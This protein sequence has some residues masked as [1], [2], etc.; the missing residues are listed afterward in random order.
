MFAML[1]LIVVLLLCLVL[2]N[3]AARAWLVWFVCVLTLLA[4]AGAVLVATAVAVLLIISFWK[5]TEIIFLIAVVGLGLWR[6][7]DRHPLRTQLNVNELR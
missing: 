1:L 6:V 7:R 3:E 4:I 5:Y 2:A